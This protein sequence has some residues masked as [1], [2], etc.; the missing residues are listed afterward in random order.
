M[1]CWSLGMLQKSNPGYIA[2]EH[3]Y[4]LSNIDSR[5]AASLLQISSAQ[6]RIADSPFTQA[7]S[8]NATE[9]D[10]SFDSSSVSKSHLRKHESNSLVDENFVY[11]RKLAL[12]R[13]TELIPASNTLSEDSGSPAAPLLV[14]SAKQSVKVSVEP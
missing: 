10:Q 11:D 5:L 13:S 14:N 6:R 7:V 8:E 2:R 3:E 4:D 1:A 9:L 12:S